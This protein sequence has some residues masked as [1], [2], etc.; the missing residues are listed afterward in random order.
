[1]GLMIATHLREL[2][3][4]DPACV[5]FARKVNKLGFELDKVLKKHYEQYGPVKR[6]LMSN[7]HEPT[8]N[9]GCMRCRPSGLAFVVMQSPQDAARALSRG[10][11]QDINGIIISIRPFR[12]RGEFAAE[13]TKGSGSE[14][15][16]A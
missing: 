16:I 11:S 9:T 1:M 12:S 14:D 5:L 8:D 7:A 10:E 6:V 13:E 3:S 4:E 2:D 15:V